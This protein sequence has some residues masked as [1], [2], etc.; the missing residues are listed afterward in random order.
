M[1]EMVDQTQYEA[2]A[3][4]VEGLP[5]V[6][7]ADVLDRDPRLQRP[8]VEVTVGP[9]YQRTP[10]RVLRSVAA[11][12]LGLYSCSPRPDGYFTVLVV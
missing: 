4:D 7:A 9:G 6:V 1:P 11:A 5:G 8:V 10:P 2:F 3:D 12:D